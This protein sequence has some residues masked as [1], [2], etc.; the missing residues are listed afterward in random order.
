VDESP[1]EIEYLEKHPRVAWIYWSTKVDTSLVRE[2]TVPG[3]NIPAFGTR[4]VPPAET[5]GTVSNDQAA[6]GQL[7]ANGSVPV[8]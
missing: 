1:L 8:Q 3:G 5:G 6:A 2:Q 4:P 7:P